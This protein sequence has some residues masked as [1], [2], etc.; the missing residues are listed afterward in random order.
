MEI[1]GLALLSACMFVGMV[2]GELLGAA[3]N[4]DSNVGGVGFAILIL[5]I[6]SDVLL[7]KNKMSEKAQRG[8][9][10]WSAMYIPIV[11]AMTARQDVVTAIKG[12]PVA[13]IAGV[14]VVIR[15]FLLLPLLNKMG[16]KTHPP[17]EAK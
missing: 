16:G 15:G 5:I 2:L 17:E 9:C 12:G 6:L 7:S 14:V 3:L 1:F 4:I 8:I 10:F 11:V 13:L